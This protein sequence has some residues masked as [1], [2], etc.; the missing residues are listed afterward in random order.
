MQYQS[1]V[2]RLLISTIII[3]NNYRINMLNKITKIMIPG[4]ILVMM[5]MQL[6]AQKDSCIKFNREKA[7]QEIKDKSPKI[8]IVGGIIRAARPGDN[9]FAKRY[10]IQFVDTGCVIEDTDCIAAYN[11]ATF[12]YLDKKYGKKWRKQVRQD[13]MGL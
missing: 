2:Y 3:Y 11:K 1:A 10:R 13:L 6:N 7:L 8:V 4:I 12:E 9:K 5:S